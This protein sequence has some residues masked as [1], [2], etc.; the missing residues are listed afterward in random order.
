MNK[1]QQA[2]AKSVPQFFPAS[3]LLSAFLTLSLYK[4]VAD[5]W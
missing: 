3:L 1:K 5:P 4:K 2:K